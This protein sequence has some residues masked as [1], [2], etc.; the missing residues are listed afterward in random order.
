MVV[1]R[2]PIGCKVGVAEGRV[3]VAVGVKVG[4]GIA[5]GTVVADGSIVE[6]ASLASCVSAEHEASRIERMA[7]EII[8]RTAFFIFSSILNL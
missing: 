6:V 3:K 8:L 7:N 1:F 4:D 5:P 2:Q